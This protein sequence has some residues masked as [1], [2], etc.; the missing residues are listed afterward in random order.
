[1]GHEK[2]LTGLIPVLAGA[3]MIYGPGM[4]ESGI[5]FD[6]GQLVLDCEFIR[7]IKYT[8]KGI[9]VDEESLALQ[10]VKEIGSGGDF[11]GHPHTFRHMTSQSRSELID[12]RNR[13]KWER[14]GAD[15]M[16]VRALRKARSILETHETEPLPDV[17]TRRI[18]QIVLET[19]QEMGIG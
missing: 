18:R 2:T 12:R 13:G 15:D 17:V 11:L 9:A 14:D 7:M 16:Y 3:D 5:T 6:F 1:V 8:L 19:E 4:L 10:A